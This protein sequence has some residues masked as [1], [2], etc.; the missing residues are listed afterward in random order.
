MSKS[1]DHGSLPVGCRIVSAT[2]VL[3]LAGQGK[4]WGQNPLYSVTYLYT[5]GGSISYAS[6]INNSGQVVGIS[7]TTGD[8]AQHA[9]LYSGGAMTDVGTLGG[10]F[11]SAYGINNS[12]QVAGASYIIGDSARHAFLYSGATM[13]D[14]GVDARL[15]SQIFTDWVQW[16]NSIA[17]IPCRV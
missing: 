13:S 12:C 16:C 17:A 6:G 5:L 11:S 3:L 1:V 15:T 10:S 14:L 2:F 8:L 9:F 7:Y 4:T